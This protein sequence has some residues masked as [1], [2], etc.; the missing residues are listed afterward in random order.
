MV[1]PVVWE[2]TDAV[3]AV[4]QDLDPQLVVLLQQQSSIRLLGVLAAV[5]APPPLT[6]EDQADLEPEL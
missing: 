4:P 6:R 5:P 1:V 2:A 3:V